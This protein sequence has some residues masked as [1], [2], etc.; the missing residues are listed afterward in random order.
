MVSFKKQTGIVFSSFIPFACV[1]MLPFIW[2][3]D[4]MDTLKA[5]FQAPERKKKIAIITHKS[6]V[7]NFLPLVL[8]KS[9]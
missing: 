6:L 7:E 1:V 8:L 4:L 3:T 5:N 9:N 2:K